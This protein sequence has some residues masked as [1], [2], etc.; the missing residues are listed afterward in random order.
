MGWAARVKEALSVTKGEAKETGVKIG[1]EEGGDG[2]PDKLHR[3]VLKDFLRRLG[4]C[5]RR[6]ANEK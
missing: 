5:S 2:M 4:G 6:L 3:E 1:L